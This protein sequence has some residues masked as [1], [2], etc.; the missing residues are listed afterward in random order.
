MEPIEHI[1]QVKISECVI[2][3][4]FDLFDIVV[5][6][7]EFSKFNI[8]NVILNIKDSNNLE[9]NIL[10]SNYYKI[11]GGS[12]LLQDEKLQLNTNLFVNNDIPFKLSYYHKILVCILNLTEEIVKKILNYTIEFKWYESNQLFIP[13]HFLG[14][15]RMK[16]NSNLVYKIEPNENL[17]I[18][19]VFATGM[20]GLDKRVESYEENYDEDKKYYYYFDELKK[21]KLLNLSNIP[22]YNNSNQIYINKQINV[23][24]E[25]KLVNYL[26][27][28]L[29]KLNQQ[30]VVSETLKIPIQSIKLIPNEL[31]VY[32]SDNHLTWT[33]SPDAISNIYLLCDNTKYLIKNII[34]TLKTTKTNYR[35]DNPLNNNPNN[36]IINS[37]E[38]IFDLE[39]NLIDSGYKIAGLSS[40]LIIPTIGSF[41]IKLKIIFNSEH[42]KLNSIDELSELKPDNIDKLL[43]ND[44]WIKF[45]RYVFDAKPRIELAKNFNDYS[46]YPVIDLVE[47]YF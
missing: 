29:T 40:F 23:Y 44:F 10:D 4:G 30:N 24:S 22:P 20:L 25:A 41:S 31:D 45:D 34:L 38:E 26:T 28:N 15:Y 11:Y 9:S 3:N 14:G 8:I 46:E 6:E 1:Q 16:W 36:I 42:L 13:N 21:I 47:Y 39:F 2:R 5:I 17:D 27:C 12:S 7:P 43:P 33:S 19:L 37:K 18:N 35:D 32:E